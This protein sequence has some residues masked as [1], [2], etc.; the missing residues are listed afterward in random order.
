GKFGKTEKNAIWLTAHRTSAYAFYQ[1]WIN[2]ADADVDRFLR[3]FTFLPQPEIEALLQSHVAD[4]SQRLAQK[5][6]A[7]ETTRLLH[8]AEGLARAEA[9]TNALFSGDVAS[10]DESTLAEA[11]AEAPSS[12]HDAAQLNGDGLSLVDLLTQ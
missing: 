11:F 6:L 9:A 3:L 7:S 8:G 12:E 2:T 4:P 1:F 5:R 10:L